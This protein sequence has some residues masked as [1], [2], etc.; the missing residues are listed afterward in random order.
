MKKVTTNTWQANKNEGE[1]MKLSEAK[2]KYLEA[3]D[4]YYMG[5]PIMS[6]PTFDRLEKWIA[7]KDPNWEPLS[8]TG[9]KVGKKVETHLPFFMP[10]LEK[11]YENINEWFTK[12]P[13]YQWAY[14]AKLDGNSVLLEYRKGKP[15]RLITRGDGEFGKDISYFLPYLNIPKSIKSKKPICFRCEAILSKEDYAKKWSAKFDNPRN[16][17]SGIL[18]RQTTHPALKD[19]HF[20]VLGVF[21]K[22]QFRGLQAAFKAGF[23]TVYCK[24]DKPR[25]QLKHYEQIKAGKFEADGVVICNPDWVYQ[26]NSAEKPKRE[27]IAY[28]QNVEF[29]DTIVKQIIYQTSVNNRLI[30]KIEVEP[31][32]LAGASIAYCTAHNAKWMLEHGIGV[33]A[34]VRLTRS[35]D[36]IPKIIDVL[37]K[38]EPTYPTVAYK[39]KG[40]H[41]VTTEK[42]TEQRV[43]RITK[44]ISTLG[45]ENVK[46]STVE[47][48]YTSLKITNLTRLFMAIHHERFLMRLQDLFGL[49][50]GRLIFEALKPICETRYPVSVLML[51][52]GC[53]DAGVGLKRLIFLEEQEFDLLKLSSWSEEAIKGSI[54]CPGIGETTASLIAEGLVAFHK[55]WEKNGDMLEPPL[56]YKKRKLKTGILSGVNVTF[57]GYRSSEQENLITS[58][59]GEIVTFSKKTTVL[60]YKEGGRKSSKVEKAGDKAM[61]FEQF[62]SKYAI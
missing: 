13:R 15:F 10:S 62:K 27:I 44:F 61:T 53:F 43:K 19:I 57:T 21:G 5:K 16:M 58:L 12:N 41:F 49:R 33:G 26:Y 24:L 25:E 39:L 40:V 8:K 47:K 60:L 36:V 45:I 32:T 28:K 20:V 42:S 51:A 35:G 22:P 54:I 2:Q 50:K 56:P 38:A 11:R 55:F 59:G 4:A 9:I 3:K 34:K 37:E 31:V 17:V 1:G 6:D 7:S 29:A 23:E 30:P 14:M 18:N 52:S 46:Q 48:M